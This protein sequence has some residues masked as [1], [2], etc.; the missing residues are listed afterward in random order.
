MTETKLALI[1]YPRQ[2][3]QQPGRFGFRSNTPILLAPG[4][5]QDLLSTAIRLQEALAQVDAAHFLTPDS[6]LDGIMGRLAEN[7]HLGIIT[8]ILR[9]FLRNILEALRLDPRHFTF[10]VSVDNTENSKPHQEPFLKALDMAKV[11]P[12]E[13]VYVGDSLTK[14][15]IPAKSVGMSILSMRSRKSPSIGMKSCIQKT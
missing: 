12:D 10:I 6:K 7:Y 11:S 15:M 5:A 2:L 4:H 9:K 3:T 13:C 1:P 14:D 8:N